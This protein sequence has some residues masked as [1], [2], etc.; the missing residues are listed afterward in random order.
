MNLPFQS[1]SP[2]LRQ[3]QTSS[4][5]AKSEDPLELALPQSAF[6]RVKNWRSQAGGLLAAAAILTV[7]TSA[8]YEMDEQPKDGHHPIFASM[9]FGSVIILQWLLWRYIVPSSTPVQVASFFREPRRGFFTGFASYTGWTGVAIH[10][11][12]VAGYFPISDDSGRIGF[13]ATG[14]FFIGLD[15]ATRLR[16]TFAA[17]IELLNPT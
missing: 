9:T 15:T 7:A 16:N 17:L 6:G 14:L 11:V 1:P 13:L 5:S 12:K 10:S 2:K 8:F 4:A 3:D